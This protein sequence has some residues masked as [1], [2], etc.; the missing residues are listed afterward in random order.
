MGETTEESVGKLE[1]ELEVERVISGEVVKL[2]RHKGTVAYLDGPVYDFGATTVAFKEN[3]V[4]VTD[5]SNK[6]I[7]FAQL[8]LTRNERGARYVV[9]DITIDYATET[10]LLA[11]TGEIKLYPRLFGTMRFA[12]IPLF[13]FQQP[14]TPTYLRLDGI[15]ISRLPPNDIRVPRFGSAL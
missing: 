15:Q 4:P 7:G 11:E 12:A 10:R 14:L 5:D 2:F 6:R 3:P 8:T 9:A 13:D 1:G